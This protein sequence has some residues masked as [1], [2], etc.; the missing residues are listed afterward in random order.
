MVDRQR[1][2]NLS[3]A[4]AVAR[5]NTSAIQRLGELGWGNVVVAEIMN[6]DDA[7]EIQSV[8]VRPEAG[9]QTGS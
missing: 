9:W 1:Y 5:D 3:D 6:V 8:V 2:E 4:L 7:F